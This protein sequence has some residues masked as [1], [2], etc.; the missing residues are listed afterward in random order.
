MGSGAGCR[1]SIILYF[2]PKDAEELT[3]IVSLFDAVPSVELVLRLCSSKIEGGI[4]LPVLFKSRSMYGIHKQTYNHWRK[5]FSA[6]VCVCMCTHLLAN[7]ID[8]RT[9]LRASAA[10]IF[11]F[12]TKYLH[13]AY[14][15]GSAW[16]LAFAGAHASGRAGQHFDNLRCKQRII[17]A[18][19]GAFC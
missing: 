1:F 6:G 18:E 13:V 9:C 17:Y 11:E 4:G 19:D 3:T 8:C 7:T 10:V 5:Q 16:A 12:T 14:Y 2:M 15:K